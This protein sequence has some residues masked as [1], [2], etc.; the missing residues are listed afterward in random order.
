[1]LPRRPAPGQKENAAQDESDAQNALPA[2]DLAEEEAANEQGE[3]VGQAD[4][5]KGQAEIELG[6]DIKPDDGAEAVQAKAD[7]HPGGLEQFE[8][9]G[10]AI[11]ETDAADGVQAIFQGCLPGGEQHNGH[12]AQ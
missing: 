8:H 4:H 2:D 10:Q 5:R 12:Q 1:M 9:S 11:A 6:Q 7:H 3:D